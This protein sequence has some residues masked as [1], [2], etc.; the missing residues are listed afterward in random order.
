MQIIF[1]ICVYF[2]QAIRLGKNF[3]ELLR[4]HGDE[5]VVAK[6]VVERLMTDTIRADKDMLPNTGCDPDWEHGLSSIFI[7][8]QTDEVS[9]R[10]NFSL[11]GQSEFSC[12]NKYT[13]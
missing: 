13:Y 3:R 5:E 6:D 9:F 8:V 7:Q 10:P 12:L 4:K 2:L 1:H 11:Q